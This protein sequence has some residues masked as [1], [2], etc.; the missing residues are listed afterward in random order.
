MSG[1]SQVCTFPWGTS[2]P[3]PTA[4]P[5]A[6]RPGGWRNGRPLRLASSRPG[7]G[8]QACTK[9]G[10]ELSQEDGGPSHCQEGSSASAG[11]LL[12]ASPRKP[13]LGPVASVGAPS[14]CEPPPPLS[15]LRVR[16]LRPVVSV[17]L[18]QRSPR[19]PPSFP[20]A[21]RPRLAKHPLV[22]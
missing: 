4:C 10:A 8:K 17:L 5:L 20:K 21:P 3:T 12:P 9:A 15:V 22:L 16:F 14:P 7:F 6:V 18:P 11:R 2:P 13:V 1:T 19:A